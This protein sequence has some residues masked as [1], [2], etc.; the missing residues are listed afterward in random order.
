MFCEVAS[1]AHG[2]LYD[3]QTLIGSFLA[4]FAGGVSVIFL[5]RQINQADSHEQARLR[6]RH[7]AARAT[8]P[9]TLSGI[10]E[11]ARQMAIELDRAK[12]EIA[13]LGAAQF[14]G[15][16]GPPVPP[17]E[18]VEDIQAVIETT[19]DSTVI[20]PLCEVIRQLQTL[21]SRTSELNDRIEMQRRVGVERDIDPYIIQTAQVYALA[22]SLF[23]Y[24]RSEACEGPTTVEWDR[25]NQ[26]LMRIG[27]ETRA[28]FTI[29]DERS[30]N[31]PAFWAR[32]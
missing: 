29:V 30:K 28:L 26:F 31:G 2:W 21:W 18:H 8:L 15:K 1:A 14:A 5:Q 11:W 22:E 32:K 20:E 3:W 24:A 12:R 10:C 23:D 9:L 13:N 19:D 27:I 25:V 7:Q 16:F 6:R 4:V 17:E